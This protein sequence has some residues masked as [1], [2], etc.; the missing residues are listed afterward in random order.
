M[1]T[2]WGKLTLPGEHFSKEPP[3]PTPFHPQAGGKGTHC[4]QPLAQGRKPDC[5]PYKGSPS[6]QLLLVGCG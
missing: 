3:P 4:I 6:F 5:I 2:M 1:G